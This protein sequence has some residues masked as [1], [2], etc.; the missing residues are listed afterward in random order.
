MLNNGPKGLHIVHLNTM[1]H[2]KFVNRSPIRGQDATP[3][4]PKKKNNF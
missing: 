3:P 4:P 2:L 1:N